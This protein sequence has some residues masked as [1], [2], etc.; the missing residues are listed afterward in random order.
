MS[1]EILQTRKVLSN[2]NQVFQP[3]YNRVTWEISP[4]GGLATDFTKSYIALRMYLTY[5]SSN[6]RLTAADYAELLAKNLMIE[7]GQNGFSYPAAALIQVARLYARNNAGA[8]LEEILYQNV[9]ASTMHQLTQ[10]LETIAAN[11]L[12]SGT[13]VSFNSNGSLASQISCLMQSQINNSD[14][15]QLP[16]EIHIPLSDIFGICKNSHFDLS[17]TDGLIIQF[18]LEPVKSLF[19]TRALTAPVS[20]PY[21]YDA[22]G[23]GFAY[24]PE[25]SPWTFLPDG[26]GDFGMPSYKYATQEYD[27]CGNAIV[28]PPTGYHYT[29][30]HSFFDASATLVDTNT[31]TLN[32]IWTAEQ[33]ADAYLAV[34]NYVQLNFKWSDP[35]NKMRSK[36]IT[37][38]DKIT[39]VTPSATVNETTL[40]LQYN[41]RAPAGISVAT[42]SQVSLESYDI[43]LGPN[44]D[45]SNNFVQA[46][47]VAQVSTLG[48][49]NYTTPQQFFNFNNLNN[50]NE[51]V[52]PDDICSVLADMGL[53][54]NVDDGSDLGRWGGGG[55][56]RLMA[57]PIDAA[58]NWTTPYLDEFVSADVPTAR[59]IWTSQAKALPIQGV[60][61]QI[62]SVSAVDA[63]GNRVMQLKDLGFA[64]MNSLQNGVLQKNSVGYLAEHIANTSD[65]I[66]WNIYFM[67]SR[68]KALVGLETSH[69]YSFQIDKA[70]IVL[71]EMTLDPSIPQ[72]LVYETLRVEVATVEVNILDVYNRQFVVN[73]PAVFNAWLLTP[74]YANSA[75]LGTS[76]GTDGSGNH[77]YYEHPE[78]LVSYARGV[79]QYKWAYNNIQDTN[80]YVE[81]QTN[82]S[83]YP[84]S[85]HIEKL[86]DTFGNTTKKMKNF[87]GVMTVPR[88][89]VDPVVCFPLRIYEAIDEGQVFLREGGFQ[90]QIEL[91]SDPVHDTTIISGPIFLFK[92][93]LKSI[94]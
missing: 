53:L 12:A 67:K 83:K 30:V 50:N 24:Q 17:I 65:N 13:A 44:V 6:T 41:Y 1:M 52:V 73:E 45:L 49:A 5:A 14:A 51:L 85:L 76:A 91:L 34:G 4:I 56:F 32:G 78:C 25:V 58:S 26:Q 89:N 81:V 7:F 55:T 94:K 46:T 37:Q 9:W 63:S 16:V 86:M 71:V 77:F 75:R 72:T 28:L 21:P 61:C 68:N 19:Q 31:I 8:P 38:I 87:S 23:V 18:E 59:Q 39:A 82:T 66:F 93:M 22:S 48:T 54:V 33:L 60:E 40:T 69:D 90:L 57:Q 64:N 70:E 42:V 10:D 29:N 80:R 79:T 62:L 3:N 88:T 43:F 11:T 84:S 20:I 47:Q 2:V 92:Q 15:R 36:M 35:S 74:Q 27:V